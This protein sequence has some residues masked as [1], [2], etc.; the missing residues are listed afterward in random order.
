MFAD[1]IRNAVPGVDAAVINNA[2]RLWAD[3]PAGTLT[4]GHIYGLFP[5]DNRIV[6][7]DLLGRDL[8][9]WFADEIRQGRRN[10][11]GISGIGV[12]A[13]CEADRMR[14]DLL[15]QTGQS[16]GDDERLVVATIGA[17]TISGGVAVAAFLGVDP[18]DTAPVV[19][20]VVEDWFRQPT[21]LSHAQLE[22]AGQRL[23]I[24]SSIAGCDH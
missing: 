12:R 24:P 22:N 2:T 9:T 18:A 17:P 21:H 5:F 23:T 7:L 3:L 13:G 6:R 20:E 4:F 16:I 10:A 19:R 1:A 8:K 11:L 14:V 15:R